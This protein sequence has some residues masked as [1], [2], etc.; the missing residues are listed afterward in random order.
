[1]LAWIPKL[2]GILDFFKALLPLLKRIFLKTPV[3]KGDEIQAK[4]NEE[5]EAFK[6]TGRPQP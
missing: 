5:K 2:L 3:E 1:M 4:V 6:K